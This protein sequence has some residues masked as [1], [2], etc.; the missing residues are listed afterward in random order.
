[1]LQRS[2]IFV[3]DLKPIGVARPLAV[4]RPSSRLSSWATIS[5]SC[6]S[7][8]ALF[9]AGAVWLVP[10]SN[11]AFTTYSPRA[12]SVVSAEAPPP[13]T[14][15]PWVE[16]PHLTGP[17]THADE[18][19][20]FSVADGPRTFLDPNPANAGEQPVLLPPRANPR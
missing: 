17:L 4:V 6:L 5:V 3:G 1:M 14:F 8:L 9:A 20:T 7:T 11:W 18:P 10:R 19:D 15:P 16:V 12:A 13:A 2:P